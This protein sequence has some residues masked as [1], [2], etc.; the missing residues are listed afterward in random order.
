MRLLVHTIASVA[1]PL[2]A[3]QQHGDLSEHAASARPTAT[4]ESKTV[5]TP[6]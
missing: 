1:T 3:A 6:C 5:M 2:R 4:L